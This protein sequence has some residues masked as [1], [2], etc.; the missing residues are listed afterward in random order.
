MLVEGKQT[1]LMW[2]GSVG[3]GPGGGV[4]TDRAQPEGEQ[5]DLLQFQAGEPW[6]FVTQHFSQLNFTLV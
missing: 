1:G 4:Q 6:G 3:E 5:Q 2:R